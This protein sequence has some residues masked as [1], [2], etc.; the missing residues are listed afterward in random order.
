MGTLVGARESVGARVGIL[1]SARVGANESTFCIGAF[2][3]G[4]GARI[5]ELLGAFIGKAV[6]IF[7]GTLVGA[8]VGDVVGAFVG[9]KVGTFVG[10]FVGALVG[11]RVGT[12]VGGRVGA[13]VGGIGVK[14]HTAVAKLH[15]SFVLALLSLH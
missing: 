10:L 13:F 5:G 12:F 3:V 9:A 8:L 11:K 2:V 14:T 6:G 15:V 7:V 1:V 4:I